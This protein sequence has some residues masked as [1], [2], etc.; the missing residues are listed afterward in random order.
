MFGNEKMGGFSPL[1]MKS[2]LNKTL[3][4]IMTNME[5]HGRRREAHGRQVEKLVPNSILGLSGPTR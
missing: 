1:S 2:G 5:V 4:K 3:E